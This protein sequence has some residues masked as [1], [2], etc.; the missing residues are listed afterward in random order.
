MNAENRMKRQ[1]CLLCGRAKKTCIC[2][3]VV[4]IFSLVEVLILQHPLELNQSKGSARL[5]HLSVKNSQLH[6]GELF[7]AGALFDILYASGKQPVLLY[8]ELNVEVGQAT[9]TRS[10]LPEGLLAAPE[11][12]RLIVLDGTWR[13]SRKMLH[14]NSLLQTL[15][16]LSLNNMPASHY[17]IRKAHTA[18]QLSTL[19]A[20]CYALM[21]LEKDKEKFLPLLDA[22]DGFIGQQMALCEKNKKSCVVL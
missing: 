10:I 5:L 15:P 22:F 7:D 21:E 2:H 13:K 14:L 20:S 9:N 8:P 19:E 11:N 3:W 16:R 17:H 12:L 1:L 4:D 18:D 6:V